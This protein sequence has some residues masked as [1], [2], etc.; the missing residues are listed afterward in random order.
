M[1]DFKPVS[2]EFTGRHMLIV[3]I[4]FFGVIIGVNLLLAT[5][6]SRSW[7]GLVVDNSY[8]AS[9]NFN[10]ELD[11]SRAQA[12]LGWK[13]R[14]LIDGQAATVIFSDENGVLEALT[15]TLELSR[16]THE[17]ADRSIELS[18]AESGQYRAPVRLDP[19][20][21]NAELIAVSPAGDTFREH[22]RFI[23]AARPGS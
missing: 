1:S 20:V 22:H 9:Q 3:M 17:A 2:G 18:E 16:P 23:I 19:G 7:T 12:K 5:V 14:L 21:W 8:V 6:A 11:A 4:A 13:S 10:A 15:V